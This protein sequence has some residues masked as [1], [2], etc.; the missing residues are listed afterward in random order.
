MDIVTFA[1]GMINAICTWVFPLWLWGISVPLGSF[2]VYRFTN[3]P[4][5]KVCTHAPA[6]ALAGNP[7]PVLSVILYTCP[8]PL[9]LITG[10]AIIPTPRFVQGAG[11]QNYLPPPVGNLWYLCMLLTPFRTAKSR[12]VS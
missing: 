4:S 6:A 9:F 10:F 11:K 8:P 5:A 2:M 1:A 7:K 3:G 12:P